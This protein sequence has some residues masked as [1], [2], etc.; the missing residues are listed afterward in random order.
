MLCLFAA[1]S[2][3]HA[4]LTVTVSDNGKNIGRYDIYEITME[5]P[6][7]YG[8]PWQDVTI[9]VAFTSG[10]RTFAVGGF[11][12]DA[13]TWKARFAPME[14][15]NWAWQLTF[16]NGVDSYKAAGGFTCV[17]SNNLGFIRIH[18]TNPYR[19][20]TDAENKPFHPIGIGGP[21]MT[22]TDSLFMDGLWGGKRI[23]L[24]R[25]LNTLAS[26]GI[27]LFRF[28]STKWGRA[29]IPRLDGKGRRVY[30][31]AVGK[32]A[33]WSMQQFHDKGIEMMM[34]VLPGKPNTKSPALDVDY[35][36]YAIN[37]WGAYV[38]IWELMNE[39]GFPG[40][41]TT[42]EWYAAL[43][44]FIRDHDPYSHPITVSYPDPNSI[45]RDSKGRDYLDITSPHLYLGY[46]PG[47]DQAVISTALRPRGGRRH[48]GVQ[49]H[50]SGQ[51][52][53]LRRVRQHQQR[54]L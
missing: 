13:G 54:G 2:P 18:P 48:P 52:H 49:D 42:P 19:L 26:G 53:H 25:Y 6:D 10:A 30:D 51:A 5:H 27:N 44:P 47:V 34:V 12:Y 46:G 3:A 15:G 45:G 29:W 7:T 41:P 35:F 14:T 20:I 9:S 43:C 36:S 16:S 28:N 37:R 33:D 23:S 1:Q 17:A 21:A 39:V 50:L 40:R 11:Y 32:V 31:V 22:G 8:N 38:S 4:A 24:Q